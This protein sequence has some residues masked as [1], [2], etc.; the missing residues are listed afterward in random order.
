MRTNS[1]P[2]LFRGCPADDTSVTCQEIPELTIRDDCVAPSAAAPVPAGLEF[3]CLSATIESVDCPPIA[4][5]A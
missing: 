2:G 5:L 1:Q 4:P 3:N